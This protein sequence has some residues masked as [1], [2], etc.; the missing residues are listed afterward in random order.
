M[1]EH[2][3][4]TLNRLRPENVRA[5]S[6]VLL[7]SRNAGLWKNE[8]TLVRT[9]KSVLPQACQIELGVASTALLFCLHPPT[10]RSGDTPADLAL[11]FDLSAEEQYL[12]GTAQALRLE[13]YA[14]MWKNAERME[15]L[16]FSYD[17]GEL[18]ARSL[19]HATRAT[20]LTLSRPNRH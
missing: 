3:P 6:S 8:R 16:R 18:C 4:P 14:L 10:R 15:E 2:P 20:A 5:L 11:Y 19:L 1:T 12:I 9:L 17:L 7:I 13:H